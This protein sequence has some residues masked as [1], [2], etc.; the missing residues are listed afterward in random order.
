MSIRLS[1][2]ERYANDNI[3]KQSI[4]QS[5]NQSINQSNNQMMMD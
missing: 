4:D 2:Y 1:E 5:I 3:I